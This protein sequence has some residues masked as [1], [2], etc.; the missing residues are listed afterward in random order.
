MTELKKLLADSE[1]ETIT[2]GT[3]KADVIKYTAAVVGFFLGDKYSHDSIESFASRNFRKAGFN[4]FLIERRNILNN[5][6]LSYKEKNE[7]CT[8]LA[9]VCKDYDEDFLTA[10]RVYTVGA[11]VG[12]IA[13]GG[14]CAA[15][16]YRIADKICE[17]FNIK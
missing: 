2:G 17:A 10:Q 6:E 14:A 1:L 8:I 7:K 11:A 3:T 16:A 12:S 4:D 15:L 13:T 9:E 5:A